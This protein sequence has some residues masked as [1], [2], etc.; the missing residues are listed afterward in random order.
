MEAMPHDIMGGIVMCQC[1]WDG[2][3]QEMVSDISRQNRALSN[4]ARLNA[5]SV[6]LASIFAAMVFG[7]VTI[8][9]YLMYMF[10]TAV[11][12]NLARNNSCKR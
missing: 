9:D 8:L 12:W 3:E 2:E 5:N 6:I 7:I 10:A 1:H 4:F 11:S